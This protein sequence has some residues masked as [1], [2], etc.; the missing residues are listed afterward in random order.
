M[1]RYVRFVRQSKIEYMFAW[2][3]LANEDSGFFDV[4]AFLLP[5]E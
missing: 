5:K 3:I 2:K 4:I 1:L